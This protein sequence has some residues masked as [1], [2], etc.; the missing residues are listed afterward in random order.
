[1]QY[2]LEEARFGRRTGLASVAWQQEIIG[3]DTRGLVKDTT[4]M[5]YRFICHLVIDLQADDRSRGTGHGTGLLISNRHVLTVG[6][7]FKVK[8]TTQGKARVWTA[9]KITV[10][11]GLNSAAKGMFGHRPFGAATAGPKD[12]IMHP[13][14]EKSLDPEFDVGL[15]RL[16][17][18]IG[19]KRFR[20]I[21]NQSLG[22]WG[23]IVTGSLTRIEANTT[24][25]LGGK[26]VLVCG[27]PGDACRDRI[28]KNPV[29]EK[30]SESDRGST[31]WLSSGKV[32]ASPSQRIFR[33]DAD[34]HGAQSGSPIWTF[35]FA[36]RVRYLVGL[37]RAG[38]IPPG[39]TQA[40]Y[41]EA[42]CIT[43]TVLSDLQSWAWR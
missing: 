20:E 3:V 4:S 13:L 43:E 33:H 31:Q 6:H 7:N 29:T 25:A 40:D 18:E 8:K 41:N 1:M 10:I 27:Y 21:R 37:H 24:A 38:H 9:Q 36:D 16:K 30:C 2:E 19:A 28:M 22:F 35:S 17:E 11:P 42:V 15:I 39:S 12:W 23:D 32:L 14:W 26:P 34:T 5:P